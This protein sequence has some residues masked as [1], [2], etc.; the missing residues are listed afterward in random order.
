M[1]FNSQQFRNSD[2][3]CTQILFFQQLQGVFALE[4]VSHFKI[5]CVLMR[6]WTLSCLNTFLKRKWIFF[7]RADGLWYSML[8]ADFLSALEIL[9]TNMKV[10][11][12]LTRVRPKFSLTSDNTNISL[13]TLDC[14]LYTCSE[15]RLPQE[16]MDLLAYSSVEFNYLETLEKLFIT[17]ARQKHFHWEKIFNTGPVRRIAFLGKIEAFIQCSHHLGLFTMTN[18]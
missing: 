8:V 2:E 10:R 12:Q 11:L 6:I 17:S 5:S 4:S 16:R 1:Y 13:G 18:F 15:G 14:S 9:K 7:G 3:L